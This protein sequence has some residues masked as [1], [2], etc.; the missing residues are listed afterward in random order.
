MSCAIVVLDKCT[1]GAF[2]VAGRCEKRRVRRAVIGP[3]ANRGQRCTEAHHN[4]TADSCACSTNFSNEKIR[5]WLRQAYS[6]LTYRA[7]R[8]SDALRYAMSDRV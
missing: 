8:L 4:A 7:H 1:C 5:L 3:V 6:V 2:E